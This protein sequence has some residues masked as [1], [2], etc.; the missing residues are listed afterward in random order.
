MKFTFHVCLRVIFLRFLI[1]VLGSVL[2]GTLDLFHE[3]IN[4]LVE[5]GEVLVLTGRGRHFLVL[6]RR[7]ILA[8]N[9]LI[10]FSRLTSSLFP[11]PV[12]HPIPGNAVEN[13]LEVR[14]GDHQSVIGGVSIGTK[15]LKPSNGHRG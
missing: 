9:A 15:P 6:L 12:A 3:H 8:S 1:I 7:F 11:R 5:K 14:L 2:S 10:S 13:T 4:A